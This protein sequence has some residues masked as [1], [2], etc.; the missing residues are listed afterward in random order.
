MPGRRAYD[1]SPAGQRF[2]MIK[3]RPGVERRDVVV[4]LNWLEELQ[5]KVGN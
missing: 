3:P 4:V 2:L 5:A 1:V